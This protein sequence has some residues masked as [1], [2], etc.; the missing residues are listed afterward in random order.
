MG[1]SHLNINSSD[2]VP[3]QGVL[4][5]PAPAHTQPLQCFENKGPSSDLHH[6]DV[7]S[8]GVSAS[9]NDAASTHRGYGV[10]QTPASSQFLDA[11]WRYPVE[12]YIGPITT[13]G[14]EDHFRKRLPFAP[15]RYVLEAQRKSQAPNNTTEQSSSIN[16]RDFFP[17]GEAYNVSGAYS[18][19]ATEVTET[20]VNSS[21]YKDKIP[22]LAYK[23]D[24]D[25]E[26][27]WLPESLNCKLFVT[28]V[29]P[30]ASRKEIFDAIK[31]G[32]VHTFSYNPATLP[33]FRTAAFSISFAN[34]ESSDRFKNRA[35]GEGVYI[36]G[37]RIKVVRDR[38]K[39]PALEEYEHMQTR[40]V[41]IYGSPGTLSLARIVHV[42]RKFIKFELVHGTENTIDG[43]RRSVATLHFESIVGQSRAAVK[44]L[45]NLAKNEGLENQIRTRYQPDP[46]DPFP[47]FL[48]RDRLDIP[49]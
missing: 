7:T 30:S 31:D 34:R 28:G 43:G 2:F 25:L 33:R 23:G 46:C 42:L 18:T 17:F 27:E 24:L 13:E 20:I 12:D 5:A 49:E 48:D 22:R 40:V 3:R 6:S 26:A 35:D 8:T 9:W 39:M 47:G 10:F 11:D 4:R 15:S 14:I 41:R 32:K 1:L 45:M 16:T 44:C 19:V 37:L 21:D 38:T 36:K 29:H